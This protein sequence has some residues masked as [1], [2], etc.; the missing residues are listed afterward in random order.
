MTALYPFQEKV[1]ADVDAA[2][3]AGRRRIIIVVPTGGGK[4]V[5]ASALI[6]RVAQ[7]RGSS[8]VLAHRR[9]IIQ[10]TSAKLRGHGVAH[11]II[12]S[13]V[14]PRRSKTSRL[15]PSRPFGSRH[16]RATVP[17][18][19]PPAGCWWSTKRIIARRAATA[20]SST[21]IPTQF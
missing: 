11:G 4:T 17:V 15:P 3:A 7:E 9:E 20:K 14:Q 16:T 2:I 1:I 6:K 18:P 21:A 13:G 12:Q 5:I 19:L 10:Q 8:L